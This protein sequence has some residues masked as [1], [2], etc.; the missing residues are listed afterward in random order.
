MARVKDFPFE[1]AAVASA[2]RSAVARASRTARRL[3]RLTPYRIVDPFSFAT[4]TARIVALNLAALALLVG[5]VLYLTQYRAGLIDL[6][7]D[8]LRTQARLI[9]VTVAEAAGHPS[10]RGYDRILANEV[11]RRL[12]LP[13][14]LRAQLYDHNGRLTG[15]TRSLLARDIGIEIEELDP[16][17]ASEGVFGDFV[18][19]THEL[20]QRA[21]EL[22]FGRVEL[23]RETP[24]AGI[25]RYR[26]VY[27]AL[28]GDWGSAQRVNSEHELILSVAV[29]VRQVKTVLGALVLSTE[30]G[31]IDQIAREERNGILQVFAVALVVTL[32][33]ATALAQTIARPIR[34]LAGAAER[35]HAGQGGALNPGRVHIPDFTDRTDEI[36]DLSGA[37]RGMTDA[38]YS[39]LEAIESFAADVAHEIKNPLS[40]MRSAVESLRVAKTDDQKMQLLKVIESDVRR[41]DRLVTDISNA[42]RLDAELVRQHK[43]SF[44]LAA[45][46]KVICDASGSAAE[47]RGV[48]I[49]C[50][51]PARP[52][53]MSGVEDRLAQVFFNIIDNAISFS[54]EG[55]TITVLA[56]GASPD[57]RSARV[58]EIVDEGPGIPEENL[59][60]IFTRFYSERPSSEEFG[61]HS[62]LGLSICR[63][64]VEAHGGRIRAENRTDRSGARFTVTLP[65]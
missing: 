21:H 37:L 12:A 34:Q 15:D 61:G 13:T 1:T 24:T 40:S 3:R 36:G 28:A 45:L 53:T 8:A 47:R 19:R 60:S 17:G 20:H 49:R 2:W 58:V 22:M 57:R 27:E 26:E 29:P 38:L 50:E 14:G 30:G 65:Q 59:E 10:R 43:T 46:V 64:I 42:S 6:K 32:L 44:D 18:A 63:Q 51:T 4:L 5:G 16:A 54:P 48:A 35:S 62:G 56:R 31:D 41:M 52:L 9:A 39:R 11:L 55:A 23:Y 33:V 7:I 25:S